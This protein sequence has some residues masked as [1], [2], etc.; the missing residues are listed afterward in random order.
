MAKS[1]QR[2]TFNT[3]SCGKLLQGRLVFIEQV[4]FTRSLTREKDE[5]FTWKYDLRNSTQVQV[6]FESSQFD[7]NPD[8]GFLFKFEREFL[9]SHYSILRCP[10]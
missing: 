8:R 4:N 1:P 2:N 3:I 7:N 5:T 10:F 6:S 9:F